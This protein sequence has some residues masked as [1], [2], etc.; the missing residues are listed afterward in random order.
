[1]LP[2]LETTIEELPATKPRYL[3]GVGDP[4]SVVEA[5]ARGVDMFD[6]VLPTRLA[7]HGTALTGAGKVQLKAARYARD[8]GPVDPACPC[9]VCCRYSAGYLRHLLVVGEPTAGR[10]LTVHNLTW[11]LGFIETIRKSIEAG[12]LNMLRKK[13]ADTWQGRGLR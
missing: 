8:E 11:M 2:A 7:R 12:E 1:M 9:R 6:C 5:V 13:V 10:L 3:M 4:V